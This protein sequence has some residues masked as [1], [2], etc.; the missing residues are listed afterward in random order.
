MTQNQVKS[1]QVDLTWLEVQVRDFWLDLTWL[2]NWKGGQRLDFDLNLRWHGVY[3]S[4]S[5][6]G[7]GHGVQGGDRMYIYG[8]NPSPSSD[9]FSFGYWLDLTWSRFLTFRLDLTW[10]D[11]FLKIHRLDLAWQLIWLDNWLVDWNGP[12]GQSNQWAGSLNTALQNQVVCNYRCNTNDILIVLW[13][14]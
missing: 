2:E 14:L 10:L 13:C 8:R 12:I 1:S 6:R 5:T 7:W 3:H 11:I 9:N 4:E